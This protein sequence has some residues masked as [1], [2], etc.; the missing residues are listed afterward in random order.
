MKPQLFMKNIKQ[1]SFALSVSFLSFFSVYAQ[2][3]IQINEGES[4]L[5]GKNIEYFVD[6]NSSF[7]IDEVKNQGFILCEKNI[8]NLGNMPHPVWMRFSV[9]S[10]T[11][12]VLY[13]EIAASL[14]D[15]IDIYKVNE[16]G[17]EQ[18][19]S[20]GAKLAHSERPIDSENWLFELDLE[21]EQSTTYYIRGQSIYPF[22]VP[23]KLAAKDQF[24]EDRQL[25]YLF[26]G[27]YL[28]ILVFA[29]IYNLFI[30]LSVKSSSYFYYLL[31]ILTSTLFY[32]GL[33][34]F[35]FQYIWPN[36]PGFNP[37]IPILVSLTNISIVFFTL[38][39][40]SID[41]KQ[42]Y[43]YYTGIAF[44]VI[45]SLLIVLNLAGQF[46]AALMLSQL[47]SLL[48][49]VYFIISG[50]VSYRLGF[51]TAKYF[52]FGWT[53]FLFFVIVFILAL[54]NV[55][56]S[57]FITTQGIFIGHMTEVLLLSFA[58]A[59]RI[60]MLQ[61]ENR[62]KQKEIILQ[63]ENN[64]QLQ[65]K[66][67]R[68]LEQKVKERTEEVVAQKDRSDTLLLNILPKEIA[69][70]LKEKGSADAQLIDYATVMFTDFKDFTAISQKLSPEE[71]VHEI[72]LCFSQ[73]D[74]I[75]EKYKIEKIKTIGDSYMAV[76]GLPLPSQTEADDV[77]KAA[78][79]IQNFVRS[80]QEE[81][82]ASN[83]PFFEIRIGI[84]TGPVVAGIVGLKKFQY[85]IWGDT[86]NTAS[87]MESSGEAGMINISASTYEIVKDKTE[88]SFEPRGKINVKG[89]G[90]ME[91]FF[92]HMKKPAGKMV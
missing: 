82:K 23:I 38:N 61:A 77:L 28:G 12:N 27:L 87:R 51:R 76:G 45:F 43:L 29:F 81:R 39:F 42:K 10:K 55:L 65:T 9:T 91:M 15:E 44:I 2:A 71:L 57:N 69:E 92:V 31:Y 20:G 13:L 41:K 74:L 25:H 46:I 68:E 83:Q 84:H 36:V 54:N 59:D 34:G 79:E 49:C 3:P 4:E 90:N 37:M 1:I 89:K 26:W 78:F 62:K 67:N 56:P 60:N 11:E 72:N 52:L 30:Y 47:F 86:V 50:V 33:E 73:F 85:D 21:S 64:K 63:L 24:V 22:Q 19:F 6:T 14:L 66:V 75:M 18:L 88:Y 48:V 7:G 53:A 80:R 17:T 8:L 16:N 58:L 40:L 35:G 32:L 5:V 70:E